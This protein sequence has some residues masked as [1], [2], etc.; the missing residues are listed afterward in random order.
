MACGNN[1]NPLRRGGKSQ[2]ERLLPAMDGGYARVDEHRLQDWIF[3]A[4]E[5]SRFL[6]YYDSAHVK[7]GDWTPFFTSDVS[8]HLALAAIQNIDLYR[9]EVKQRFDFLKKDDHSTD[10]A[11]LKAHFND[12]L[13]A[14]F[15]LST[16]LDDYAAKLPDDLALKNTLLNLIQTKL[17][18]ALYRLIGYYRAAQE[19]LHLLDAGLT[20]TNWR[21]LGQKIS[22]VASIVSGTGLSRHWWVVKSGSGLFNYAWLQN[23]VGA[24]AN[25]PVLL[26][27]ITHWAGYVG[28]VLPDES[29]FTSALVQ[30]A[31]PEA[32]K[33]YRR[34]QHAANHNL[35]T[36]IFDQYLSGFTKL[37]TDASA[38]LEQTL[39]NRD[40]HQPHYALFLA[41]LRLFQ[42]TQH[43]KNTLTK[44]HLDFYYTEVLRLRQKEALP[45]KVHVL[46]ELAKHVDQHLLVKGTRLKAG[47]DSAGKDVVYVLDND[48]TFNKGAVA[49]LRSLYMATA[50]DSV[51]DHAGGTT[52]VQQ[53]NDGRLFAA[54]IANSA[55]GIGGEIKTP[56]KEWHPFA[57]KG[58]SNGLFKGLNM[59]KAEV[60]FAIASHYLHLSE[61]SRK[62]ILK[63]VTNNNSGLSGKH[64]DCYVTTAKGWLK[65]L[66]PEITVAPGTSAAATPCAQ[67]TV[68]LDGSQPSVAPYNAAI[69]GGTFGRLLPVI[70]LVLRQEDSVA[71]EYNNLRTLTVSMVEVRVEVGDNSGFAQNGLKEVQLAGDTGTLDAAKPFQ[72]FGP[73]PKKHASVIIGN[74]EVFSKKNT[75]FRIN[76]EWANLPDT[77]AMIKYTA[78]DT[79]STTPSASVQFLQGGVWVG[80]EANSSIAASFALFDADNK[81]KVSLGPQPVPVAAL[82]HYAEPYGP[83][84]NTSTSG[85]IK[86]LLDADFG[87]KLYQDD[88]TIHLINQSKPGVPTAKK[89][90]GA[91]PYSPMVQSI[92]IT[93]T[94]WQSSNL[95]ATDSGSF[96]SRELFFYH[97]HPFGEAEQHNY[98][99]KTFS[100]PAAIS[101]LP[102][103][104]FAPVMEKRPAEFYI[105]L[106]GLQAGQAVN[107]LF[108][109]LEGTTDPKVAKPENHIR[110]SYLSNNFWIDFA[111]QDFSDATLGLLQSGII[112]FSIPQGATTSNTLLP[113]GKVW[114]RAAIDAAAG[115]VA[116]LLS[117]HAQAAIAT[118][119]PQNNAPDFLDKPMHAGTVAKLEIPD[120]AVKKIVQPFPAFGGR[121]KEKEDHFYM[122]VG[123][124]LRHKSRAITIWDYEQLIL[125][126]FPE[127]YK[128]KC[129]NHTGLVQE[130]GAE[131]TNELKPGEVLIITIPSLKNRNDANPLQPFTNQDTLT[132]IEQFIREKVSP[133]V[134]VA[135]R[136]PLFEEV[137]ISFSLQLKE[138]YRDFTFYSRLLGEEIV[139]FLTPWA[140]DGLADIQFGGKVYKSA[141]INFIEERPYVEYIANVV[142][143]HHTG[144]AT[145]S[146]ED[147]EVITASTARSILVS[148]PAAGHHIIP[149]APLP[150]QQQAACAPAFSD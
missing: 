73:Q 129:L 130:G 17:S 7:A 11:G 120:A 12:L 50:K 43:Q 60:G 125:E 150:V 111:D 36:A 132:R 35:F 32:V 69:H 66:D 148:V 70:K 52:V 61:G 97:L 94:S 53:E 47:K 101:L 46:V 54:P 21:I 6:H 68:S 63:L 55:D 89:F 119:L 90:D 83:L 123:E 2:Q 139:R 57:N 56:L 92:Y 67:I 126:A 108:Q 131:H 71:Y 27:S 113:S 93:Y 30:P 41:F 13:S 116:K 138:Q 102:Q 72:P 85:F 39:T 84:S 1:I 104:R 140:Y 79:D 143:H 29:I 134:V 4:S 18:F 136:Q 122:R 100:T 8:A 146:G 31:D 149:A 26:A 127:I 110:W 141:L 128:V 40:S 44:R 82:R 75:A 81:P 107:I 14:V 115:A 144:S 20:N 121:P 42:L 88:L 23:N 118:F 58:F 48:H 147:L 142:L 16:A 86:L 114:L 135:A 99:N 96:E 105:G 109:V 106:E 98:L 45:N 145:T 9:Q 33:T 103:L 137:G 124:R 5:F 19:S 10:T 37:V 38:E 65:T 87:H 76:L 3:F 22:E 62:I 74:K 112:A 49:E 64:F 15:T 133:F 95:T 25:A 80:H 28:S 59:P 91:E 51:N 24:V 78:T 34:L 117:V 77:K